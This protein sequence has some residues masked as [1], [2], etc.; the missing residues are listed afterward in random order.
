MSSDF[1][2]LVGSFKDAAEVPPERALG[3]LRIL[4]LEDGGVFGSPQRGRGD[5]CKLR[6]MSIFPKNKLRRLGP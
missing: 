1:A 4:G 2:L 3:S 5:H 6:E